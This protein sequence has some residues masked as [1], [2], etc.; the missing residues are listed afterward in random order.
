MK[1]KG[2]LV[3]ASACVLSLG[4]SVFAGQAPDNTKVNRQDRNQPTADQQKNNRTD[5]E[6]TR[7]IRQAITKDKSLST[8]AK[9]I[10]IITQ[11]G[12]VTLRGPVRS[13][14]DKKAIE[15]K[16]K[17]VAGAAHVKNE[18]EIVAKR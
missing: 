14:A 16:A 6:I 7:D 4:L 12:N 8:Y 5:T 3:S 13:E 9:N 17:E 18:I 11:N 2:R 15:G 1:L 10:K